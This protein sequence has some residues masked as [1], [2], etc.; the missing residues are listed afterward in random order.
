[1]LRWVLENHRQDTALPSEDPLGPGP[2]P[3]PLAQHEPAP[4]PLA[5]LSPAGLAGEGSPVLVR[6]CPSGSRLEDEGLTRSSPESSLEPGHQGFRV[7]PRKGGLPGNAPLLRLPPRPRG[8]TA[9]GLGA[10]EPRSCPE[11]PQEGPG[12]QGQGSVDR[13]AEGVKNIQGASGFAFFLLSLISL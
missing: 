11:A 3:G 12:V 4:R 10:R 7:P 1:M 9:A 6:G 13:P 8:H 5:E 2:P